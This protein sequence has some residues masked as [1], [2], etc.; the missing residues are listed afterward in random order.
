[1]VNS[2]D[3]PRTPSI[4]GTLATRSLAELFVHV[5][6]RRLTGRRMVRAPDGRAGIVDFWRAQIVRARMKPPVAGLGAATEMEQANR[7][8]D[9]LFLMPPASSFGFYDEKP[10]TVEPPLTLE[11]ISVVWRAL[12]DAAEN[13]A[14]RRALASLATKALR[15]ANEAPIARVAFSPDEKKLCQALVDRPMTL[16]EMRAAFSAVP[17]ARI[18]RLGYLLQLTGCVELVRASVAAMPAP[19]VFGSR[20]MSG[21][22]VVA[23]LQASKRA[24]GSVAPP[25]MPAAADKKK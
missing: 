20:A 11:P 14:L 8:L 13:E 9:E 22:A 17:Y 21:E 4:E 7:N 25:A 23:A 2:A 5:R 6:T 1:M 15:I 18:E 16:A 10:S 19:T 12:R 24:Q 3:A